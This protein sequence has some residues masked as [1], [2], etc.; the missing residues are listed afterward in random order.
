[1]SDMLDQTTSDDNFPQAA[2]PY[3]KETAKWAKFLA[4]VSFVVIGLM[5]IMGLLV[6]SMMS[7]IP[8]PDASFGSLPSGFFIA[9]FIAIAVIMFFPAF[10]L[11]K[12]ATKTLSG[13]DKASDSEIV[14]GLS[15][16]KS[17]F[18]FY[19]IMTIIIL[20]LYALIFVFALIGGGIAA[21][22]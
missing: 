12:F 17:V 15:N 9:Y 19:G 4:I 14:E 16:L 1:M 5:L 3:L 22:S 6:G 10:Y 13:L 8:M 18:K 21:F 7:S 11:Y 20:A 2:K